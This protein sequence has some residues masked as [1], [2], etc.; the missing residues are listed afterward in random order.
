MYALYL[1]ETNEM[2]IDL[3]ISRIFRDKS[4]QLDVK[5]IQKCISGI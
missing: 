1:A 2:P 5:L 3:R 4:D